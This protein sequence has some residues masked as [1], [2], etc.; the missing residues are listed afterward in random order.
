[1]VDHGVDAIVLIDILHPAWWNG[2]ILADYIDSHL[3]QHG[4]LVIQRLA[5]HFLR[6]IPQVVGIVGAYGRVVPVHA[7]HEKHFTVYC[8]PTP[9][10][11]VDNRYPVLSPD[12]EDFKQNGKYQDNFLQHSTSLYYL[13]H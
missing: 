13:V 10:S 2:S 3:F 6:L 4:H 11:I 1:M 7:I 8:Q 5:Y 9:L 12:R